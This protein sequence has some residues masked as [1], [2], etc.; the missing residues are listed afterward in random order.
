MILHEN[1][2]WMQIAVY[3]IVHKDHLQYKSLVRNTID[4]NKAYLTHSTN[5]GACKYAIEF[6][7]RLVDV[8]GGR[9]EV[10]NWYTVL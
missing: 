4:N 1:V 7:R 3:E 2:A 10:S 6:T 9:N 5:T 8:V